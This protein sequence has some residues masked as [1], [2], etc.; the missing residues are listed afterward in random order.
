MKKE[1]LICGASAL[2]LA[3]CNNDDL[4]D[5]KRDY[6][7]VKAKLDSANAAN[8]ERQQ[9]VFFALEEYEYKHETLKEMIKQLQEG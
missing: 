2:A 6:D 4:D 5:L 7:N 9:Q 8:A 1:L 3:A